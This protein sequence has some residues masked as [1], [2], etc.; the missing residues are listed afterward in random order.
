MIGGPDIKITSSY[1]IRIKNADKIFSQTIRIYRS[2][3]K[4][5]VN[6]FEQEWDFLKDI[7]NSKYQAAAARNLIHSAK[8]TT[9]NSEPADK[10]GCWKI[11][12]AHTQIVT[13][14]KKTQNVLIIK[15]F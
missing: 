15:I 13:G 11:I 5:C 12:H 1:T 3:V 8:S 14:Q 6:A 7:D 9:D 4:F 2:A 10:N